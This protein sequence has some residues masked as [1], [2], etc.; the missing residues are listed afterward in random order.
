[1]YQSENVHT[2]LVEGRISWSVVGLEF[3]KNAMMSSTI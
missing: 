2:V 1:M 3:K